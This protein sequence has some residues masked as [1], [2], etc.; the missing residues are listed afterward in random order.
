MS[1]ARAEK[2]KQERFFKE[3]IKFTKKRYARGREVGSMVIALDGDQATVFPFLCGSEEERDSTYQSLSAL[4]RIK[5]VRRYAYVMDSWMA[6]VP[7]QG[8]EYGDVKASPDR[9]EILL[10]GMVSAEGPEFSCIQEHDSR[11]RVFIGEP[12]MKIGPSGDSAIEG[13]LKDSG[14]PLGIFNQEAGPDEFLKVI[15]I[16][17]GETAE[18]SIDRFLKG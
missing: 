9:K 3:F 18:I 1:S 5:K 7:V 17:N 10:W 13:L 12:S 15:Q 14:N 8:Y 4:F 2:M 6:P 11:Q 16:F